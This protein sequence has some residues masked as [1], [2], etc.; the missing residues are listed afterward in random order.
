MPSAK[1]RRTTTTS[2]PPASFSIGLVADVQYADKPDRLLGGGVRYY[3]AALSRLRH[4]VTELN[5]A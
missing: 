2:S 3:R 5:R 4:S 1:R